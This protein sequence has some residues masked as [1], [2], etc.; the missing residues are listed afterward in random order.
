[1]GRTPC[2]DREKLKKGAWSP[3]EDRLL[4]QY[5]KEHGHGSWR[6]L[7]K[8]AGLSRCGKSCR[9]RW[10]NYLRPDIKRGPFSPEEESAI[11]QLHY[12]LGNRW[13]AI[14]SHLPGRTDNEI[15]N[16]WNTNL[17]KPLLAAKDQTIVHSPSTYEP[18]T[19]NSESPLTRHMIQWESKGNRVEAEARLS[20]ESSSV[21]K[22]ECDIFLK[23]WNS[24]V[25]ESFRK[26]LKPLEE[27]DEAC[28]SLFSGKSLSKMSEPD[29]NLI[30]RARHTAAGTSIDS[31]DKQYDR[32]KP[33]AEILAGSDSIASDHEFLDSSDTELKMMFDLPGGS[34]IE[35]LQGKTDNFLSFV[36]LQCDRKCNSLAFI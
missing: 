15:K 4:V 13:A 21:A 34:Y 31:T 30:V 14:A 6:T 26:S 20:M 12:M 36:D 29:S 8:L 22:A 33:N 25:G 32:N 35:F 9:L 10:T 19:L 1:M 24:E 11:I 2:C 7:P 18:G 23:L 5:I 17:K 16:F 3:E 27:N 28:E